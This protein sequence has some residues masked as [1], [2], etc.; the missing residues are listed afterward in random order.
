MQ[1]KYFKANKAII[2]LR[3]IG[4]LQNYF[5]FADHLKGDLQNNGL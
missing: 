2:H 3:K 5:T 1:N 4:F